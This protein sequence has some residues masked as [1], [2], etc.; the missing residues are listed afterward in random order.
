MIPICF[1]SVSAACAARAWA[2]AIGRSQLKPARTL[3][4]QGFVDEHQTF[5]N[6]LATIPQQNDGLVGIQPRGLT[7]GS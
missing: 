7:R 2:D 1:Q 4:T 5:S 6:Q 3:V